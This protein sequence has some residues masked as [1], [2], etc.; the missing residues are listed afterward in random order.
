[1]AD[2][3][4]QRRLDYAASLGTLVR[5]RAE[6][7]ATAWSPEGGNF[8]E[9]LTNPGRGGAVYGTAQ[10]G[11]NAVS[12]A[13]FYLEKETKDMKLGKPLGITGCT[14]AQCPEALESPWALRSKEHALANLA[15]FQSLFLGG[16]PGEEDALGFDD[17]LRDMGADDVADD[18]ANALTA[19]ISATEAVPGTFRDALTENETELRAAHTAIQAVTDILKTDFLSILDLCP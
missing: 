6:E 4:P 15:G 1:M 3:I 9:E 7:L 10:E 8:I 2:M 5:R 14:T 17:L 13:M 12:D 18:M 11:L 16:A 19:A